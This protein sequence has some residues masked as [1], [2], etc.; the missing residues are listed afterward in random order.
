MSAPERNLFCR[1]YSGCLS[2]HVR[3]GRGHFTCEGCMRYEPLP[4]ED[5]E[6]SLEDA[7]RCAEF[8]HYLFFHDLKEDQVGKEDDVYVRVP[9][10]LIVGILRAMQTISEQ[11]RVLIQAGTKLNWIIN[12]PKQRV[13]S[14]EPR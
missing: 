6:G 13:E 4:S 5:A 8:L 12:D 10:G 14:D 3:Y 7:L 2:V 11:M 1:F 9:V